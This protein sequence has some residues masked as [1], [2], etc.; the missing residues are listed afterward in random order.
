MSPTQLHAVPLGHVIGHQREEI[1]V[2]VS[3]SSL[4][5]LV[6][7][8]EVSPLKEVQLMKLRHSLIFWL[9]YS[10]YC[11]GIA[12]LLPCLFFLIRMG[13]TLVC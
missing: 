2:C 3:A 9:L 12:T 4:E 7:S 10:S 13:N 1:T 6:D 11:G 8:H 5:E